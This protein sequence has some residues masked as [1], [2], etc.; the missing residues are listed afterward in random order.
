MVGG[1]LLGEVV[2]EGDE[3]D[4]VDGLEGTDCRGRAGITTG[5]GDDVDVIEGV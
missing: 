2:I 4:G 5:L 1:R 3:G